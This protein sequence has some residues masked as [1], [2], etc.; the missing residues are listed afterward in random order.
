MRLNLGELGRPHLEDLVSVFGEDLIR[1]ATSQEKRQAKDYLVS[2]EKKALEMR[3]VKF[4]YPVA[5]LASST[6]YALIARLEGAP[7]NFS[8]EAGF[9][10]L[11]KLTS[12]PKVRTM[13]LHADS[14]NSDLMQTT[15]GAYLENDDPRVLDNKLARILRSTGLDE[16]PQIQLVVEGKMNLVSPRAYT[17]KELRG[18]GKLATVVYEDKF[19]FS[20]DLKELLK[21][22]PKLLREMQPKPGIV[23][24]LSA[25]ESKDTPHF[26]RMFLDEIYLTKAS[27]ELDKKIIRLTLERRLLKRIGAR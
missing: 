20:D 8:Y 4:A 17:R 2:E 13:G 24:L 12:V 26:I 9:F 10:G 21:R 6:S 7:G 25:Y 27:P 16:T 18:I 1:P 5:R 15:F 3:I 23:S 11:E 22:Y 19:K 14:L